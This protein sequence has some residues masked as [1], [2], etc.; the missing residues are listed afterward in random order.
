[1]MMMFIQRKSYYLSLI[2]R[3]LQLERI[4]YTD[5]IADYVNQND[6]LQHCASFLMDVVIG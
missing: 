1:M 4:L 2:Y 5:L 6:T 3:L